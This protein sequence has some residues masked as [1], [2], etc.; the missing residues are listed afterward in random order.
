MIV[1]RDLV[2]LL[3]DVGTDHSISADARRACQ[4]RAV[5]HA[6]EEA[7][8]EGER[9]AL[10]H[11]AREPERKL[12]FDLSPLEAALS[13]RAELIGRLYWASTAA[14]NGD[15]RKGSAADDYETSAR[16]DAMLSTEL[17]AL[18]CFKDL[19]AKDVAAVLLQRVAA[20][21][22]KRELRTTRKDVF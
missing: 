17:Q 21:E 22:P 3:V 8:K 1:A 13:D 16:I 10:A 14:R 20:S 15:A 5:E 18:A 2:S 7:R 19:L 6:L 12:C 9:A 4:E 11:A